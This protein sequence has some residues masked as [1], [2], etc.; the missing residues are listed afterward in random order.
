ME[1]S[2]RDTSIFNFQFSILNAEFLIQL[3]VCGM[4]KRE[5]YIGVFDSGI[6]GISVLKKLVK[7]LPGERFLYFGDCA[8]APY[9]T[10]STE[11]VKALTLAAAQ[12]LFDRGIKALVVACNTATAAAIDTLREKYPQSIIV[13]IEPAVKLAYD[14]YPAGRVAVLATPVTLREEKFAQLAE[15]FPQMELLSIPLPGLVAQIEAGEDEKTLADFLRPTLAPYAGRLDA[16]VL[17]CTH[18]PLIAPVFREI[19]GERI[20]LLDGA[21]GT[22]LQTK[23]RLE[24]AGLLSQDGGGIVFASSGDGD[25]E[26]RCKAFLEDGQ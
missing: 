12:R 7:H 24:A 5:D 20:V 11:A 25:F 18:Y 3:G 8:N 17:G 15:K 19:L 6:G 21:E 4:P 10:K 26:S 2:R 1:S 16:V 14:H 9:G 13:G 23:R 22:A